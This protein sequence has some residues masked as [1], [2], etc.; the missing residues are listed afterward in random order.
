MPEAIR[1]YCDG[2]GFELFSA[3][4]EIEAPEG[5]YFH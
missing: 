1:F 3:S 4:E 5:R 2:L